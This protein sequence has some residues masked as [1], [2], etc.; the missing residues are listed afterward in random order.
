[1]LS[2]NLKDSEDTAFQ[3]GVMLM[4][5][6]YA[7]LM[8]VGLVALAG[9]NQSTTGGGGKTGGTFKLKG[10]LTTTTVKHGETKTVE[11]TASE[12]KNF[13]EDVA[14]TA[15]IDPPDKGVTAELE[16]KT[17]KAS[18]PKTANLIIKATDKAADGE[19]V[20]HVTGKPT[21]GEPTTV[22]VKVKVEK[23]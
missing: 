5:T 18:D 21:T 22:D 10:P 4:K 2:W 15:T 13:K 11:I 6:L 9:C 23:K 1:M 7:G 16:P 8:V 3:K 14:L 17:I 20:I 12:D 19:Y